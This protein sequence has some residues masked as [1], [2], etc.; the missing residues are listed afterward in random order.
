MEIREI[1]AAELE[2]RRQRNSRYSLRAFARSIGFHHSTLSRILRRRRVTARMADALG[3]RLGLARRDVAEACAH[4]NG[5]R[6]LDL[7]G[8]PDFRPQSRWL[9]VM[10]GIP[11]DDVNLVLQRLLQ[12]GRLAMVNRVTWTRNE[13]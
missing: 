8:H 13:A 12:S 3:R 6:I 4:E 10:A 2:R 1:L 5:R 7:V 9:A 11:L